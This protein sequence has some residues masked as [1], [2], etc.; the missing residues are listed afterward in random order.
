MVSLNLCKDLELRQHSKFCDKEL[1]ILIQGT[2]HTS[3]HT[4]GLRN[5]LKGPCFDPPCTYKLHWTS[6]FQ[7]VIT[8]TVHTACSTCELHWVSMWEFQRSWTYMWISVPMSRMIILAILRQF[9][10]WIPHI[11]SAHVTAAVLH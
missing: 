6:R 10:L 1:N 5:C 8:S 9:T 7:A 11:I 4:G 3:S 2:L